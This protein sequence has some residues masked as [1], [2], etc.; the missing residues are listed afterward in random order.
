MK[1]QRHNTIKWFVLT[2]CMVIAFGLAQNPAEAGQQQRKDRAR[3]P[4]PSVSNRVQPYCGEEMVFDHNSGR[5][6]RRQRVDLVVTKVE[7]SRRGDGS[8]AL[9]PTIR[10]RCPD[11]TGA[12]FQVS[13]NDV[14]T[15]MGPLGGNATYTL[16]HWIVMPDA[17]SFRV[18]VDYKNTVREISEGNNVCT[19]RLRPGTSGTH[20]CGH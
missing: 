15:S 11:A 18:T 20:I 2:S 9:K 6:I 4:A 5:M 14:A 3:T 16:G 10:N 13:M 7:I 8:A 19:A 12:N 17:S 1:N